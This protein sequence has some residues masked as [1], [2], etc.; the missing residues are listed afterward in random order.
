M[1]NFNHYLTQLLVSEAIREINKKFESFQEKNV[2]LDEYI[3]ELGEKPGFAITSLF[4]IK[5]EKDGPEDIAKFLGDKFSFHIFNTK[6]TS[7]IYTSHPTKSIVILFSHN[8]P[9]WFNCIIPNDAKEMPTQNFFWF[10]SYAHFLAGVYIGALTHFGYKATAYLSIPNT[11]SL[12]ITLALSE[13][14]DS[15]EF[16]VALQ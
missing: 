1:Q 11:S 4:K 2:H 3:Q 9:S 13:F 10:K 16:A 6:P 7:C 12:Q 8:L 14:K 5:G 15:W